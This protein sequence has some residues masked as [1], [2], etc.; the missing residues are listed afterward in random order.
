ML[1]YFLQSFY[2]KFSRGEGEFCGMASWRSLSVGVRAI[3]LDW[4]SY[5]A[6]KSASMEGVNVA[7]GL[8]QMKNST[9]V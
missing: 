7:L 2:S 5:Y 4:I 9:I 1:Y 8:V 3:E 6:M